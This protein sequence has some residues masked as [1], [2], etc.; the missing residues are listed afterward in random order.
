M[1]HCI[2]E[3]SNSTIYNV[4]SPST[5]QPLKPVAMMCFL[6]FIT[7]F[8]KFSKIF[9][10]HLSGLTFSI[11]PDEAL[12]ETRQKLVIK[13]KIWFYLEKLRPLVYIVEDK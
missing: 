10:I 9:V 12:V 4:P 13:R 3:E 6:S 7:T 1:V 8:L 11:T 2:T 5:M